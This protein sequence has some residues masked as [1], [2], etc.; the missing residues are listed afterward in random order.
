MAKRRRLALQVVLDEIFMDPPS[1]DDEEDHLKEGYSDSS[2][3]S[4]ELVLEEEV[5]NEVTGKV[6]CAACAPSNFVHLA[7]SLSLKRQPFLIS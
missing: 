3:Y 2:K 5:T 4:P 6:P 7:W 1:E